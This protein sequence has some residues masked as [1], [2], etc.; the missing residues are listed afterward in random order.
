MNGLILKGIGSFY[1]IKAD[2]G[3]E[4]TCKA[5]GRFRIEGITPLPGDRVEF[6][7]D[8]ENGFIT[9]IK[10]RKN[11]LVRP[12]VANLD[13]LIIVVSANLPRPD[14][15]LV[16]KLLVSCE[17]IGIE[18]IIV[19]NKCDAPREVDRIESEYK[20]TGY[21]IV[22]ASA[23]RKSGVDELRH[24]IEGCIS[25]FA[26]QSAVGKSSLM[27]ALVPWAAMDTGELSRKTDRGRHTTRHAELIMLDK[28]TALVDTPGFSLLDIDI[29]ESTKLA[30]AYPE[31]RG[32]LGKC[33]YQ[34]CLHISEPDCDV[35][36]AVAEGRISEGRYERYK[37]L[38]NDI[39]E[40]RKHRYD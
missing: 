11:V 34:D 35:K 14:L 33:R 32:S 6:E 7:P 9:S 37:I 19:I 26:G 28:N 39:K 23:I 10:A 12:A 16:D 40:L 8:G 13:K 31:M 36:R 22:R 4:Y 24:Q 2:D 27:N 29:T 15:L 25:C 5:R 3:A 18:P 21:R 20:K 1:T 38:M 30:G 17:F